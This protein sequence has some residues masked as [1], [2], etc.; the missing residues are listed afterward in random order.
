MKRLVFIAGL[1]GAAGGGARHALLI[2]TIA[3]AKY[4]GWKR[5]LPMVFVTKCRVVTFASFMVLGT[6]TRRMFHGLVRRSQG[7]AN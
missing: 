5:H 4:D 1:G 6:R 2:S 3:L 7:F